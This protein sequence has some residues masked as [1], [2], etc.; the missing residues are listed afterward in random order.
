MKT[1][2][3]FHGYSIIHQLVKILK[4]MAQTGPKFQTHPFQKTFL[5]LGVGVHM[6]GSIVSQLIEGLDILTDRL[7]ALLKCHKLMELNLHN[8]LWDMVSLEGC[9]ELCP[10]D[11]VSDRLHSKESLPPRGGRASE[12]MSGKDSLLLFSTY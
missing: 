1:E 6:V 2:V 9:A 5:L 7:V 3:L 8:T 12:L 11:S 4:M 10:G